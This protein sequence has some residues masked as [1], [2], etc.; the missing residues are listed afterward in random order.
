MFK[1]I[2]SK[3]ITAV[4]IIV[5]LSF[6][7]LATVLSA[8]VG[9]YGKSDRQAEIE[10]ISMLVAAIVTRGYPDGSELP[11]DEFLVSRPG[12]EEAIE[13]LFHDNAKSS[14]F[15]MDVDKNILLTS[16]DFLWTARAV[17]SDEVYWD[18]V[19][20]I[21]DAGEPYRQTETVKALG[22]T[23]IVY[24]TPLVDGTGRY[25]G[26]VYAATSI[27]SVEQIT[28]A[29]TQTVVMACLWVML[30]VLVAVYF[31]T[32]R[33]VDPIRRMSRAAHGYAKGDFS[34]RVESVGGDEI[35]EL[36]AALNYMAGELESLEQKRN[37][38]ISDVSHELRSP[39]T[40]MLGFV[41]AVADGSLPPERQKHYLSLVAEEIK[42]LSRLV[43]DLL[44][45]SRLEMGERKM[46]F[47][48]YDLAD[49]AATVLIS[50]EQR[51]NEKKLDVSFEAEEDKMFVS[52]D[53]DAMYRVLYNLIENAVKFS[54]EGGKL[55]IALERTEGRV[56]LSVYNEGIGI[57]EEDLPNVFD[58]FYKSDKSR[59]EDKKG[60]GLGLY[61]VKTIVTAHGGDIRAESTE[62]VDTRFTMELPPYRENN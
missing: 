24:I 45:V 27:E 16:K 4:S 9:D 36:S 44:D 23:H 31:I 12:L 25:L 5:V 62:G 7:I 55:A 60:V 58:R 13:S 19:S 50:L 17:V 57:S 59:G 46:N 28:K 2:F 42:R 18:R 26:C 8:V 3:Y 22:G 15:V 54:R 38:F 29:T 40:S 47:A 10:H 51:I 35:A 32:E 6:L 56:R 49:N 52:A 39:M 11:L 34:E 61:F 14:V 1:S 21:L 43:A 37:R 48:K 30:G 53:A 20:V 33:H 41:E